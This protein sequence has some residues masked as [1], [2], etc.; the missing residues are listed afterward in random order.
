M[1][2]II[3]I[4]SAVFG[5]LLGVFFKNVHPYIPMHQYI[6]FHIVLM[7]LYS[8]DN[9]TVILYGFYT[10]TILVYPTLYITKC[11]LEHKNI[12]LIMWYIPIGIVA[13][14]AIIFMILNY[15]K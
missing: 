14:L 1:N 3:A 6:I 4:I 12:F 7:W 5:I 9:K 13:L 10:L 2:I 15:N 11:L 8:H